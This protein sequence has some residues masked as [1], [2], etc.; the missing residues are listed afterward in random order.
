MA[1]APGPVC[2]AQ[3]ARIPTDGRN[4]LQAGAVSRQLK[5]PPTEHAARLCVEHRRACLKSCENET[6]SVSTFTCRVRLA[7][8]DSV[9]DR[10]AVESL[11][12]VA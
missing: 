5:T 10:T 2:R 4:C 3:P 7:G 8:V 11:T 12:R 6:S 1:S 9:I